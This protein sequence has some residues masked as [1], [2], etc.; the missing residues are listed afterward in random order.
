LGA[1]RYYAILGRVKPPSPP[2]LPL[3]ISTEL[4]DVEIATSR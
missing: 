3:L 4:S 2:G 1:W